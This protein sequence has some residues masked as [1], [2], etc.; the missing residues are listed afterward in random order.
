V[1]LFV[2]SQN[3]D[4]NVGILDPLVNPADPLSIQISNP[5][6]GGLQVWLGTCAPGP[7]PLVADAGSDTRFFDNG[8]SPDTTAADGKVTASLDGSR[9]VNRFCGQPISSYQWYM[10]SF[11]ANADNCA[12]PTLTP[13][14]P[15]GTTAKVGGLILCTLGPGADL[16]NCLQ[17]PSPNIQTDF[18]EYPFT[19][20]VIAPDGT[21]NPS[22]DEVVIR[23]ST[24]LPPT[25]TISSTTP[26][27]CTSGGGAKRVTVLNTN[28]AVDSVGELI[29]SLTLNGTCADADGQLNA[30]NSCV[31]STPLP[32]GPLPGPWFNP[33]PP[34]CNGPPCTT[35][36]TTA[37]VAEAQGFGGGGGGAAC[38]SG[39]ALNILLIATDDHGNQ[40]SDTIAVAVRA[41]RHDLAL[42][43]SPAITTA[44]PAL[45]GIAQLVTVKVRNSGDFQET[46]NVTLQDPGG[47]VTPVSAQPITLASCLNLN[48]CPSNNSANA[49]FN[50]TPTTAS[51][52]TLTGTAV[53]PAGVTE[54]S[55]TNNVATLQVQVD[56][57]PVLVAAVLPSSRSV[58][59]GGVA[60][61]FGLIHNAGP[62]TA[63]QCGIGPG[64][65][66]VAAT[67]SYQ[68][69][70][71]ATNAATGPPNT[72]VDIA[73][74]QNGCFIF[75]FT[76]SAAFAPTD[77]QLSFDCTNANPVTPILGVNTLN[78]SA[79]DNDVL[80]IVAVAGTILPDGIV[81]IPGNT[82]TGV[83]VVA[84]SNVS[85]VVGGNITASADTGGVSLPVT[86]TICETDPDTSVCTN[87]VTPAASAT[88][89][90]TAGGTNTFGIF[91]QGNGNITPDAA[92]KRIFVRFRDSG[93]VIRGSTSVAVQT[94]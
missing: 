91:V 45:Q 66:P 74:G 46:F 51:V 19:L 2:G 87:P 93:N 33:N 57:T 71:C 76:P 25:A 4:T 59:V 92:T 15:G 38:P 32:L 90:V 10:G 34:T 23:A 26:Q 27:F 13:A 82:G 22:C 75:F 60:S 39:N 41:S 86:I 89:N 80:D 21:P 31:W 8:V 47:T 3:A 18:T 83:F 58:K 61:A 53:T 70:V 84:T 43:P 35:T 24:N 17:H 63:L 40:K 67:F 12:T 54:S 85:V 56:L 48:P 28:G 52:H 37:T 5:D 1:G 73:A 78:L 55:T 49:T 81:H 30:T 29:A 6:A 64:T 88:A 68:T 94:N 16:V 20:Q 65:P 79:S 62:V 77:V 14:L 50:W 42:G 11:S 7:G 9:S 69:T 72:P 44:A 36:S